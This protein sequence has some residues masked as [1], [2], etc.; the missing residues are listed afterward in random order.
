MSQRLTISDSLYTQLHKSAR[1]RG[2]QSVEQL[3][4]LWQVTEAETVLRRKAVQRIRQLH[5]RLRKKY[6]QM[7]DSTPLICTDRER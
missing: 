4:E 5:E 3:L 7:P 2:L 1:R 6:G